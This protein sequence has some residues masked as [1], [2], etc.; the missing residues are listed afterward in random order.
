MRQGYTGHLIAVANE[1]VSC[2]E[3]NHQLRQFLK[4][5]L[6]EVTMQ[7]WEN[8]VTT[9]LDEI[10]KKQQLSLVCIILLYKYLKIFCIILLF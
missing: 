4:N 8:F 3:K 1:I 6:A 7:K 9:K 2:C 5:N 10:N